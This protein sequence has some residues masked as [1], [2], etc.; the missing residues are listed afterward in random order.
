[1]LE[2]THAHRSASV[3]KG[4]GSP[5]ATSLESAPNLARDNPRGSSAA[6]R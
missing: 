2:R 3:L 1:M 5:A 6:S 4:I